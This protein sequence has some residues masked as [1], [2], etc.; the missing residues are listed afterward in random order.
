MG[1]ELWLR[2]GRANQP[3]PRAN[4]VNWPVD[5]LSILQLIRLR[6]SVGW[7]HSAVVAHIHYVFQYQPESH[8]WALQGAEMAVF[9]GMTLLLL[10]VTV[11]AVRRWTA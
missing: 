4:V 7:A 11:V 1:S 3:G 8:Y 5:A 10:G 9:L 6:T 2:A